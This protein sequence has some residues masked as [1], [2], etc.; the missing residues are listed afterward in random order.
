MPSRLA[1]NMMSRGY[2]LSLG[3]ET[4]FLFTAYIIFTSCCF[5]KATSSN[6]IQ[7]PSNVIC[8]SMAQSNNVPSLFEAATTC[9]EETEEENGLRKV[10]FTNNVTCNDGTP[11]GFYIREAVNSKKWIVYLEGG[12]YCY[13]EQNC[14][15]RWSRVKYLMSS[16]Q[17]PAF[18]SGHGILSNDPNE[19]PYWWHANHVFVPY[20]T[21]DIWSGRRSVP[22]R[23][24]SF[25]FMGAV[26]I[27]QMVKELLNIGLKNANSLTIAGSSA[28]GVGVMLNLEP[29]QRLLTRYGATKVRLRGITDSGWFLDQPPFILNS[30]IVT[31]VQAV[32]Q[33]FPM[34]RSQIPH[35][36]RMTY[37]R[38]LWKCF[39]GYRIYPTLSVP[40]FVFQWLFDEVQMKVENVGTPVT[41]QQWEYIHTMGEIL[42]NSFQNVTSVFAPSCISHSILSRKD[43]HYIRIDDISLPDALRCWERQTKSKTLEN[44]METKLRRRMSQMTYPPETSHQ[45]AKK[46]RKKRKKSKQNKK[47]EKQKRKNFQ[48]NRLLRSTN[49]CSH[50]LLERC[51]WPQCNHYCP[52]LQNPVTGEELDLLELLKSFGLDMMN[53]ATALG[54]DIHTLNNM[55]QRE[56]ISLLTQQAN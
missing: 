50:R 13:S 28:G 8:S 4:L 33:G 37:P 29:V 40:L 34:W 7:E 42:R 6:L 2:A 19:N 31:P 55:G 21:S 48:R 12:W 10:L 3:S 11:A 41:K 18:R 9:E 20:C 36:C 43:W 24:G 51:S 25:T 35:T 46:Q 32:K 22:T 30:D 14:R 53:V 27:K 15:D 45:S 17:W 38:E 49:T 1:Y 39:I 23:S 54:V 56:L 16:E 47:N 52:K 5:A 26:I 44:A